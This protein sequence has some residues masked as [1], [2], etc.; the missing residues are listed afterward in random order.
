MHDIFIDEAYSRTGT[1]TKIALASW[2]VEQ[3][4]W[5][6]QAERLA[7]LYKAPVLRFLSLMFDALDA[8]ASISTADLENALFRSGEIDGADDIP[9]M[10]RTD[11][12]WS[13]CV[14]YGVSGL[15][16]DLAKA[17]REIGT[18]DIY[19]DPK[20]LK[21]EHFQAIQGTLQKQ[22]VALA[23]GYANALNSPLLR[24]FSIRRI[25]PV[26]KAQRGQVANKFQA[27]IWV[28]HKLCTN[29]EEILRLNP[30]RITH[31]DITDVVRRTAQQFD[32]IPFRVKPTHK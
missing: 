12:I 29:S 5:S 30:Q 32:G 23:K 19:F 22:V 16:V 2:A 27:G 20:S 4:A 28:A 26:E 14:I 3:G 7:E 18:V 8:R 11:N 31:H 1:R 21:L 6:R 13:Q 10:A 24:K 17:G 9:S 15:I 25:E